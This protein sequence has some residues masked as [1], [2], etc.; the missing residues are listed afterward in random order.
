[1][2]VSSIQGCPYRGVPLY[3]VGNRIMVF[4]SLVP[5]STLR[6]ERAWYPLFAHALECQESVILPL[7]VRVMLTSH[8]AHVRIFN[9]E[10][11]VSRDVSFTREVK[12][13]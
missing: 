13:T 9:G 7:H 5:R 4:T 6:E 12:F 11:G 10:P 1:M 8:H 3:H 2:E